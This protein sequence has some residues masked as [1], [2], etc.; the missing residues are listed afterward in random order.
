VTEYYRRVARIRAA[1][2]LLPDVGSLLDQEAY[3]LLV[4]IRSCRKPVE[5]GPR[6]VMR[7][8]QQTWWPLRIM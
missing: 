2:D 7:E 8:P 5:M 4:A 1:A 6:A 3:E